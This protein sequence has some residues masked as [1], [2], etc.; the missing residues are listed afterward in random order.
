MI[1]ALTRAGFP[2]RPTRDGFACTCPM[3]GL[4]LEV[5]RNPMREPLA[6]EAGCEPAPICKAIGLDARAFGAK[7]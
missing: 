7:G 6:C 5:S 2:P 1:A 4:F 3:C